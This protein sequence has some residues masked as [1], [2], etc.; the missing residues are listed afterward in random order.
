MKKTLLSILAPFAATLAM[1]HCVPTEDFFGTGLQLSPIELEPIFACT[2]CGDFEVVI[3]IQTFAD[4]TL[5]VEL[6]PENPPLDVTVLTD[7]FRLDSIGGLP[8]GLTYTTDAA[9]DTTYDAITNP[10]GYWINMGD[11]ATGFENTS[12]CITIAGTAADWTAATGGGPNNDGL[13]PLTVFVDSRAASFDPLAIGDV[14]GFNVWLTEMGALLDA[15]GDPNFT[16]NGIKLEGLVLDVRASG[17]GIEQV[18]SFVLEVSNYPNPF[19]ENTT[20]SFDL[21]SDVE[22]MT[23]GV[24][25][26]FGTRVHAENLNPTVGENTVLFDATGLSSGVYFYS[27]SDGLNIITKKMSVR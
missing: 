12:G 2:E 8:V 1:A 7:F 23:L 21:V 19:S 6:A 14:T 5:S 24:Y 4:T 25:N 9:F 20:I 10:F 11:T 22:E 18:T 16:P 27:L 17:V 26:V 3:S 13:Y 15:F